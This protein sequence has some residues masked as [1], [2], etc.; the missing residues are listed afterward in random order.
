MGEEVFK[1]VVVLIAGLAAGVIN[2]ISA[3]GSLITLPAFI[4]AGLS[5][6]MANGTNRIA[7]LFQNIFALTGF[8]SKNVK[9]DGY[10]WWL[11]LA[12]IPGA[13]LGALFAVKIQEDIFNKILSVTLLIFL[14]ITLF[15]PLK[16]VEKGKERLDLRHKVFG[17]IAYFFSGIYGGFIQAGTGFFLMAGAMLI[18]KFDIVKTNYYKS[19]VMLMYTIAALAVFI[20][21]GQINWFYGI[22]MSIGT[23]AGGF[24]GSRWSVEAEAK[25]IKRVMV[26]II[27]SFSIYLWVYK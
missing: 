10:E 13:V 26:L 1:I 22:I 15:N 8:R 4:F 12:A 2:A 23:S 25:W 6:G 14:F 5:P 27:V 18:H 7:I 9:G 11:G 24:I 19:F 20:W 21:A 17:I 16:G 3:A